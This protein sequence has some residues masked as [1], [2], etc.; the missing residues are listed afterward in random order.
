[1]DAARARQ[2]GVTEGTHAKTNRAWKYWAT[3]LRD[4][5]IGDN[6]YLNRYPLSH[7]HAMLGAF[8]QAVRNCAF[9]QSTKGRNKLGEGTCRA[10]LDHVA[11]AFTVSGRPDP[12]LG[13]DNKL[14]H[15]LQ[16]QLKGYRNTNAGT[17][18]Q[19][20]IPLKLILRMVQRP[21]LVVKLQVFHQLYLLGFFFAAR[22]CEILKVTGL[23]RRTH[24]L[25][26]C[27]FLFTRRHKVLPRTS[28]L[29]AKADTVSVT[30]AYQKRET[31]NDVVTQCRLGDSFACPVWA[32]AAIVHRMICD[33]L[34]KDHFIFTFRRQDGSLGDLQLS[35]A[36][37]FLRAFI[38]SVDYKAF[39]LTP[40][41]IGLHLNRSSA[42][43][44]MYL[45]GVPVC[46]IMLIGRW[47]SKAFLRYIRP[48]VEQFSAHVAQSMIQRPTYHHLPTADPKDPRT[49]NPASAA[50]N[51]G[52][53]TGRS[54]N[55]AAWS[56]WT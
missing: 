11:K 16:R 35:T 19:Q 24:P 7:Q 30:F 33:G 50:A 48:Q 1:M 34:G 28:P 55:R 2:L 13:S 29:L 37:Q 42:A 44:A 40:S 47:S 45:N 6:L 52:M 9:S 21:T 23:E 10:A 4:A 54:I 22:S 43:M 46:T 5:G 38:D 26:L 39:G 15:V 27:N 49:H 53:G 17:E 56:V 51:Q 41:H 3:F 25:R 31:Q 12:R 8:L 14:A 32:V 36:L 20:A 18:H